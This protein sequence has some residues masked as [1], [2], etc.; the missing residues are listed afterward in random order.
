MVF[1]KTNWNHSF[2]ILPRYFYKM[3]RLSKCCVSNA[4]HVVCIMPIYRIKYN[5]EESSL[6]KGEFSRNSL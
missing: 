2:E 4:D 5:G 6:K 3:K 1:N